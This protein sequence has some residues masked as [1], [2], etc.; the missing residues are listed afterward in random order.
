[1]AI[2]K[3]KKLTLWMGWQWIDH[4]HI[5]D[6]NGE[7]VYDGTEWN[8]Y[9]HIQDA[10]TLLLRLTGLKHESDIRTLYDG[11]VMCSINSVNDTAT[12]HSGWEE[13]RALAICLAVEKLIGAKDA[14]GK[15][16]CTAF[17]EATNEPH[18]K[19]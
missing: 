12:I 18:N 14:E 3:V 1:M 9:I 11:T 13:T 5:K 17:E 15:P 10:D 2:N 7:Y 19:P 4:L 16:T 8:P 6:Q